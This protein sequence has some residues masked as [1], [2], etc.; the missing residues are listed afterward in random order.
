MTSTIVSR[1]GE[2][3]MFYFW[4]SYTIVEYSFFA[5][6]FYTAFKNKKSKYIPVIG[7][8]I[9]YGIVSVT[10][11]QKGTK[12][13]DSVSASME[14]ILMIIYSIV[15]LYI[16]ITSPEIIF[17]YTTK[18]FW[19]VIAIFLYFSSTLFLFLFAAGFASP[20]SSSYWI[21]NNLFEILKNALFCISFAIK[22]SDANQNS[23]KHYNPDLL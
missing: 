3:Y 2:A 16:Q 20:Q 8:L 18:R 15:F 12:S 5:F 21:I 4:A 13:F 11:Y 1:I 23:I 10:F 19:V 9:F 14:A 7:T 17:L 6:F 22:K